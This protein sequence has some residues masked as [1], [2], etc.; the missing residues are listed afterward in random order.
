MSKNALSASVSRT[1]QWRCRLNV[2]TG[3]AWVAS[4]RSSSITRHGFVPALCVADEGNMRF[5]FGLACGEPDAS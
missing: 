2:D 5:M 4:V 3:C 1:P